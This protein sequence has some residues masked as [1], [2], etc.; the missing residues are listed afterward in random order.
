MAK[1]LRPIDIS[2]SPELLRLAQEVEASGEPRL[3]R[4]KDRDLAVVM[5]VE[6][7]R[8]K[9]AAKAVSGHAKTKKRR[10]VLTKD[11]PLLGLIGIGRSGLGDVSENKHKYLAEAYSPKPE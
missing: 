10:G 4:R 5:P 1:E 6:S 9:H 8:A 7:V 2:G 3:L 11:D